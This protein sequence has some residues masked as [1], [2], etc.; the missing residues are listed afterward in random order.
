MRSQFS[1]ILFCAILG[2]A[3]FG[4]AY[5]RPEE[6]EDLMST[7]NRPKVSHTLPDDIETG[8]DILRKLLHRVSPLTDYRA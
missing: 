2:L 3:S 6:I 7:M 1:K 8:D 4:G 5:M